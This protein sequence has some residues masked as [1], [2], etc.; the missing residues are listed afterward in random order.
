MTEVRRR[1][2]E[3]HHSTPEIMKTR[4]NPLA[5]GDTPIASRPSPIA[6]RRRRKPTRP[7]LSAAEALQRA[8]TGPSLANYPAI[9]AGF[10]AKGIAEDDI[11]P[12]ENVFTF[13]AWRAL[14]RT[15]KKGEHGVKIATCI[16]MG[17]R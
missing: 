11:K 7:P 1:I 9:Y 2:S 16:P 15:V 5:E 8:A 3:N 4:F 14:G 6:S 12:R 17:K 13:N 10:M